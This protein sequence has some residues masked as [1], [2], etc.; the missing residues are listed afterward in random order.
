MSW[1]MA[2]VNTQLMFYT[3]KDD[4]AGWLLN[5]TINTHKGMTV[6]MN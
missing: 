5:G 1:Y 4:L 2:T 6:L 3:G